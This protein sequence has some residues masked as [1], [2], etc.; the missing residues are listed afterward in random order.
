MAS[1][2]TKEAEFQIGES[3]KMNDAGALQKMKSDTN[4]E[5]QVLRRSE[6]R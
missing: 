6:I 4:V 5:M 2:V 1:P 3:I